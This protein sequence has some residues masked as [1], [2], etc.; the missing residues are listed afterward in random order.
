[1]PGIN[2]AVAAHE[3][4]VGMRRQQSLLIVVCRRTLCVSTIGVS[5]LTV[6]VSATPPTFRSALTVAVNEPVSS[7]PSRLTVLK[8]VSVNV[9]VYVPA[10]QVDDAVLAGAVGDGRADLF[11]QHG[12]G[13]FDG[14]A[15]QHGAGRVLDDAGDGCLGM[16]SDGCQ[17]KRD[18]NKQNATR[19]THRAPFQLT[20]GGLPQNA[21]CEYNPSLTKVNRKGTK[22]V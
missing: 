8:P 7:M 3:R 4:A 21:G 10:Q 18:E 11:D 9:T 5:P 1:M 13:G 20:D 16:S 22:P 15:R 17:Q 12:T 19:E 2:S 14:H 6:I